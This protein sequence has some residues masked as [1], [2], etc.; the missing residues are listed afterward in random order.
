MTT[1]LNLAGGTALYSDD[2][3]V[4]AT[5]TRTSG[6]PY[7]T[8]P[9]SSKS[10]FLDDNVAYVYNTG[11]ENHPAHGSTAA[12]TCTP[13]NSS[14][15]DCDSYYSWL[16][17]TVGGKD[18]NGNTVT[19]NGHNTAYSI[20]PKGWRLPTATTSNAPAQTNPNWKTG[21]FY[22]LATAYGVD[23]ESQYDD[24]GSATFYN[25]VGPGTLPNF[26]LA[27]V[28]WESSFSIGGREGYY[29]TSSADSTAFAYSLRFSSSYVNSAGFLGHNYGFPVRCILRES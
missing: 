29:W 20:C 11:K 12:T 14:T 15:G 10:G 16:A 9:V 4:A 7:Y 8:L 5:N 17:A 23:L 13:S 3:D 27:G 28:Y 22:K 24:E 21:D 26:L 25:N 2:S 1:S 19:S 18:A 6:T